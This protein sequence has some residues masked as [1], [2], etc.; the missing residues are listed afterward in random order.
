MICQANAMHIPLA[1]ESVQCCVTSPPYW[2]LRKYDGEQG[3]VW[4]AE[5]RRQKAES[6]GCVHEWGERHELHDVREETEHGKSRT[7]E[8]FYGDESRRFDGN[9]QKHSEGQWCRLCN[10]WRGAFG[11]EP[12]IS[13]YVE[14]TVQI[15]REVRRVLRKDGVCFY[16]LG[17]SYA[18]AHACDRRSVVGQGSPDSDCKRPNRLSGSLKE[19]DL[20]LIPQRVAL[21]AQADGWWVRS[22]IVWAKPNPMPESVTD[23]PTSAWE[24]VLM[25][26]KSARYFW[27]AEAVREKAT[28]PLPW[29]QMPPD[30]KMENPSAQGRHGASSMCTAKT[31][32]EKMKWYGGNRNLRNVW[33]FPTAPFPEAHFATFPPELPRRC[34]LAATSEKGAC[35]TCGAPWERIIEQCGGK[36]APDGQKGR[37]REEQGLRTSGRMGHGAGWRDNELPK[38]RSLGFRPTCDCGESAGTR[39]CIVLDPFGGSGTTVLVAEQLGRTGIGLDLSMEY[40]QMAQRRIEDKTEWKALETE[41]Q[42]LLFGSAP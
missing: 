39:P 22:W 33:D 17:D 10:A 18:S 27:D 4:K 42:P 28:G 30:G 9:H 19:K 14:H 40:C 24:T 31:L 26:T 41:A 35:P 25:L 38:S 37:G 21:A 36:R 23:R 34:I 8:R 6:D 3:Y 13:M 15:L 1:D 20:C 5:G 16:N 2:G 32:E 12:Q 7:T 11:L 29:G